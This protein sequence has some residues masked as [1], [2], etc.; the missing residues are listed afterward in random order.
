MKIVLIGKY[1]F[2]EL[3]T[4]PEKVAKRLF[5]ELKKKEK[6][7]YFLTHFFKVPNERI[8]ILTK[9]FGKTEYE[10]GQIQRRGIIALFLFLIKEKPN[11][12]HIVNSERFIIPIYLY[13]FIFKSSLVV[14]KHAVLRHEIRL[15]GLQ[16]FQQGKIKDIVLEWLEINYSD[17]ICFYTNE[18]KK[19]M[20][21]IY[22][23]NP[24][25]YELIDNG[26]DAEFYDAYE[27][28][29]QWQYLKIVF[30]NGSDLSVDRGL[31]IV[32]DSLNCVNPKIKFELFIIGEVDPN[33][34]KN[35][36]FNITRIKLMTKTDLIKFMM[37]KNIVIKSTSFDTFPIFVAECMAMGIIPIVST[38]TGISKYITTGYNGFVYDHNKPNELTQIINNS[39]TDKYD[40]CLISKNAREI[41]YS[42]NWERIS[43]QYHKIYENLIEN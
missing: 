24:L 15:S 21:K 31:N 26:I 30:Y 37:D 17:L 13:K 25:K 20:N 7:V 12:I 42:L 19:L 16:L 29:S 2:G 6:E 18:Q 23:K 38:N 1:N 28:I 27:N 33:Q 8:S 5:T 43:D 3:L 4:G 32:I 14:T 10:E 34:I 41:Y 9:L 11:I 40:Y 22:G 35:A 39:Q 36:N